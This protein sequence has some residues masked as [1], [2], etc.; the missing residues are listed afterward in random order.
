MLCE[1]DG[2]AQAVALVDAR[3]D[4][5]FGGVAKVEDYGGARSLYCEC[6]EEKR[7]SLGEDHPETELTCRNIQH[8]KEVFPFE[9]K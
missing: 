2:G 8:L 3:D 4:E 6:Y 5:Q 7:R 1:A 9:E